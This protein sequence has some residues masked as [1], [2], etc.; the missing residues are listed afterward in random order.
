MP[1]PPLFFPLK[2]LLFPPRFCLL[3][4]LALN[5]DKLAFSLAF[6]GVL[7]ASPLH[8]AQLGPS[9]KSLKKT[10]T[11]KTKKEKGL[12]YSSARAISKNASGTCMA[13]MGFGNT[14]SIDVW[15]KRRIGERAFYYY[16]SA[17]E[18]RL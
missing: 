8:N 3:P 7:F 9:D 4:H 13:V 2:A 16:L 15:G 1:P 14:I 11:K 5:R 12:S 17:A 10:K 6:L 18:G